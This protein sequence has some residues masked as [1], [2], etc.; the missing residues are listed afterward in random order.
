M[1]QAKELLTPELN[2]IEK[3]VV[4]PASQFLAVLE[5]VKKFMLKRNHKLLDYDRHRDNYRKL[6]DN[7]NRDASD[8]RRLAKLEQELEL[9]TR[10]YES[11]NNLLKSQL[12]ILFQ[13]RVQFIDPVFQSFYFYQ[14]KVFQT[15]QNLFA[16]VGSRHFDLSTPVMQGF[17]ARRLNSQDIFAELSLL[18]R[19][20]GP[21]SPSSVG[22]GG[23]GNGSESGGYNST[24]ASSTIPAAAGMATSYPPPP[25]YET[26]TTAS[27]SRSPPQQTS[28]QQQQQG[29]S[30]GM[31]S[32]TTTA[33]PAFRKS[34]PPPPPTGAKFVIALYDFDGQADGD[35]SFK[36]DDK[37]EVIQKTDS[38]NDWWTGK[39]RGVVGV[40][41]ANYCREA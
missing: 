23:S 13:L 16:D 18:N 20:A 14:L 33:T 11:V 40:F 9:A 17:D 37:I 8:E 21:L 36:K 5:N 3:R 31:A 41:P 12:P 10:E 22:S 4:Q 32:A 39:C 6:K 27:Y 35:L 34:A 1:R 25:S 28:Q 19:K 38:V 29:F 7:K 2:F 15:L 30:Y 24:G 26:S